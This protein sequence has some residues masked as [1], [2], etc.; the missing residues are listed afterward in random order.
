MAIQERN[1][2]K[3]SKSMKEAERQHLA[4]NIQEPLNETE[5]STSD[6]PVQS[7]NQPSEFF[8]EQDQID[9]INVYDSQSG[10]QSNFELPLARMEKLWLITIH[11][12]IGCLVLDNV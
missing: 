1:T 11:Y 5:W 4:T 2:L 12:V 9:F 10:D 7:N 6:E 8:L 3:V